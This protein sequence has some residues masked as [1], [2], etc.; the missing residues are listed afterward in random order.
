ML[1]KGRRVPRLPLAIVWLILMIIASSIPTLPRAAPPLWHYDKVLH[2]IEYGVFAWLWGDVLR[3]S[4]RAGLA[5][6]AGIVVVIGGLIWAALDETYQ[7]WIGRSCDVYDFL[8]DAVAILAVQW[9]QQR[10]ASRAEA[11]E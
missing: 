10:R 6:H 9:I 11:K 4:S 7:G 3:R 8:A 2:L 5:H 1:G